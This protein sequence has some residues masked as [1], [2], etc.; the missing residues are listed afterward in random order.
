MTDRS[1]EASQRL[2]GAAYAV[3]AYVLW[4]FLPLYFVLLEP[5]GPWEVVAWRVLLSLVFYLIAIPIVGGWP[6]LRAVTRQRRLVLWT[7]V[8]GVL[9]YL[10]WQI[11]LIA[12]LTGHVIEMSLGYFINPIVTVLLG[13]TVLREHLSR[14]Q[15]LAVGLAALAAL[16]IIVAYGAFPWLALGV[17]FSFGFYGLV[18][19]HIGPSVDVL[20]G[21]TLESLWLA[22][23]AIGLLV[24]VGM[25][26]GL[27][28]GSAGAGHAVLLSLAGVITAA[29]LMLFAAG[30]RRVPLTVLGIAQF[31]TPIMQLVIGV[32]VLGEPM[33]IERWIG[34][35]VVWL[36]LAV[37]TADSLLGRNR[38]RRGT[39]E[40]STWPDRGEDPARRPA[41]RDT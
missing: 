38:L 20:S 26:S 4:G 11:F 35:A 39:V 25:T 12:T 19:K 7:G 29:P 10:N 28:M 24:V 40:D 8:A 36:A 5:T 30:A 2:I 13:V 31:I 17:A 41:S 32:W 34:F 9:I 37:L 14:L 21:L 3:G 16:I 1:G 15:W 27:T 22:P 6:R 18:K 33:P 23:I